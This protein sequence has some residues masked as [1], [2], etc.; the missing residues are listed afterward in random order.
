MMPLMM[1]WTDVFLKISGFWVKLKNANSLN[2]A[3]IRKHIGIVEIIPV[4]I[5]EIY[6]AFFQSLIVVAKQ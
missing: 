2:A 6:F 4:N 5:V 3:L 1:F